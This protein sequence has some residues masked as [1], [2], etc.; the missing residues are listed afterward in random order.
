MPLIGPITNSL[1]FINESATPTT[2]TTMSFLKKVVE[3][4][5]SPGQNDS[6]QASGDYVK[7][8]MHAHIN[9]GKSSKQGR[10]H[11][12]GANFPIVGK[13]GHYYCKSSSLTFLSLLRFLMPIR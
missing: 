13:Y 2:L 7:G 3:A 8:I 12:D 4:G 6:Q 5:G 9:P 11:E 1:I 10:D